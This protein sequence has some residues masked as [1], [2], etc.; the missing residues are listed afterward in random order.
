MSR[1][2]PLILYRSSTPVLGPLL[3]SYLILCGSGIR[4]DR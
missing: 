4:R 2:P 1:K 3:I